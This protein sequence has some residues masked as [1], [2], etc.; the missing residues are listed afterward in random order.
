[1]RRLTRAYP[2]QA[3]WRLLVR[4]LYEYQ[5]LRPTLGLITLADPWHGFDGVTNVTHDLVTRGVVT[6]PAFERLADGVAALFAS[7]RLD[8]VRLRMG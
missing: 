5:Y 6:Q 1:M 7:F 8:T 2:P 4:Y 3:L